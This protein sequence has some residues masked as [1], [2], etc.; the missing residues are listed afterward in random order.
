MQDYFTCDITKAS[1][2][3]TDNLAMKTLKIAV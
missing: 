3:T 2:S 1:L